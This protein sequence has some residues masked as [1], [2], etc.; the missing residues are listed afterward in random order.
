MTIVSVRYLLLRKN[1]EGSVIMGKLVRMI[2]NE[3]TLCIM[4]C[5]S[6]DIV[7]E[8]QKI[9]KTSKVCSAALG[10]L[11]T[12]AT[13]MG[14]MLKGKDSSISLKINGGGPVGNVIAVSNSTGGVKGCIDNPNVNLPLKENGKLDVSA[15][16]GTDG[17]VTVIKDLGLKEP[18]I[19]QVPI[20]T[21]EIAEDI[22][23]YYAVSEQVPSVCALGVLVHRDTEDIICSGGFIIQLLPTADDEIITK[24]ESCIKEVKPIT[25]MLTDGLS[26]E[27]ICQSVLSKEFTLEK[28]DE[29]ETAYHCDCSHER[30]MKALIATGREAL[31]EMALDEKTEVTCN[32]CNTTYEIPQEEI[33]KLLK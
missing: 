31:S 15:A 1:K 22:T 29:T 12:A 32:F 3:G 13:M 4:A 18:Y 25:T 20:S 27:E 26:P 23:T 5:D 10:R 16:V 24:V 11:L 8:M 19:G 9:H 17:F 33:A 6:T 21:G 30:V 2:D 7:T 14:S 28:L